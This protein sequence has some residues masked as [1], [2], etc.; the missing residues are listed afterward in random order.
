LVAPKSAGFCVK[1]LPRMFCFFIAE[2]DF[3]ELAGI[4]VFEN[5]GHKAG[6]AGYH[7][8]AAFLKKK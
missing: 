5:S 4:A 1:R 7:L 8:R 2:L 3:F 6:D